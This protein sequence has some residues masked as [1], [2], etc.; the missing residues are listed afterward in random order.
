[1]KSEWRS[2]RYTTKWEEILVVTWTWVG[3][4]HRLDLNTTDLNLL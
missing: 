3:K 1:L 4:V 2:K